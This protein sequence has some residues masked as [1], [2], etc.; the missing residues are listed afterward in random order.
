MEEKIESQPEAKE[1][2]VKARALSFR[3]KLKL[4]KVKILGGVLTLVVLGGA[5]Y[6]VYRLGQK[7]T[8]PSTSPSFF[9]SPTP[10]A[11]ITPTLEVA[12]T[13]GPTTDW[14]TYTSAECGFLIRHPE[15]LEVDETH[16]CV[17][18]SLWGPS[19]KPETEFYDGLSLRFNSGDL[20]NKTLKALAEEKAAEFDDFGEILIP[21][22]EATIAGRTG[23]T[24]KARGL[25]DF[26]HFYISPKPGTYL[27]IVDATI[28][29]TGQGFPETVSLM[30]ETLT[31]L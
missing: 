14:Q 26:T 31:F 2:E 12:A 11:E 16:G 22:K 18:F 9:S 21:P 1:M 28:D 27:E 5:V 13:P 8:Q 4:T 20:G 24:F 7:Q 29:P 10:L 25:G 6:G 17:G 3:E 23:Y 30:L 19:Q 15:N